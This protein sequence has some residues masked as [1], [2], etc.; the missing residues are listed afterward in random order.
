MK[1]LFVNACARKQ[2]RTLQL[3]RY[4]LEKYHQCH[5][6]LE[7]EEIKICEEENLLPL[8]GQRLALRE[9]A[10]AKKDWHHAM[11]KYA[12]QWKEADCIVIAAPYWDWSFPAI[13]KVYM[14]NIFISDF[15]FAYEKDGSVGLC[16]G[17][18]L[19]YIATAGGD[20]K[21]NMGFD[22]IQRVAKELG[23]YECHYIHASNLDVIGNDV[24]EILQNVKK[25]IDGFV[26][27]C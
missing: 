6:D 18:K 10:I 27:N 12:R 15:I 23:E 22:Y 9:E 1:L 4:F 5:N 2:S 7:I 14:E 8:N 24:T 13:L 26:K 16:Q 3:G 17:K 25:E 21:S 11:M 19:I 20:A